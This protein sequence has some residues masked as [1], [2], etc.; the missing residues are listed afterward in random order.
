MNVFHCRHTDGWSFAVWP[1]ERSKLDASHLRSRLGGKE[2]RRIRIAASS[3]PEVGSYEFRYD[4]ERSGKVLLSEAGVATPSLWL[5][6]RTA[7]DPHET[8]FAS[9]LR[10]YSRRE[11]PAQSRIDQP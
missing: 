3:V 9:F 10:S 8:D 11:M 2:V 6:S 1:L 7:T 4:L 5:I